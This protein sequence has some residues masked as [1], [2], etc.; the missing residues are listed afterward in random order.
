MVVTDSVRPCPDPLVPDE[1][2]ETG[3]TDPCFECFI[4]P[5]PLV[6]DEG[7]ECQQSCRLS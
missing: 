4:R 7:G 1:G 5:D 3:T 6:P 2:V